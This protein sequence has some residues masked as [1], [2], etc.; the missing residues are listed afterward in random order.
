MKIY[1]DRVNL[2][3]NNLKKRL[4]SIQIIISSNKQWVESIN[5]FEILKV[6]ETVPLMY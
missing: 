1:K 5:L 4:E 6:G 2:N 3:L